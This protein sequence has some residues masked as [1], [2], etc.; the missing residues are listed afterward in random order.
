MNEKTEV[1]DCSCSV[2][3]MYRKIAA[4]F[5]N[6]MSKAYQQKLLTYCPR[7]AAKGGSA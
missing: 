3:G 1:I 2:C 4:D 7:C 6:K 5:F